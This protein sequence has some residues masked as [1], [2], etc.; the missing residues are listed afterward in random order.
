M[1]RP[2]PRCNGVR[3]ELVYAKD[4]GAVGNDMFFVFARHGSATQAHGLERLGTA[5]IPY[6]DLVR[7]TIPVGG[8]EL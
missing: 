7:R 6:N 4:V 5:K 1:A 8:P 2:G 3:F